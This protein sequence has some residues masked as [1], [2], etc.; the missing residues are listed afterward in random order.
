MPMNGPVWCGPTTED[1]AAVIFVGTKGTGD[2]WYG[3]EQGPCLEC[4]NRGLVG[5]GI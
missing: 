4:D 2:T 3:N 5:H 1:K